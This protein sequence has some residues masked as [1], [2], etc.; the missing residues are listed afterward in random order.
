MCAPSQITK[1]DGG[2]ALIGS[3]QARESKE[4]EPLTTWRSDCGLEGRSGAGVV[5]KVGSL[6]KLVEV[7]Y[8][9]GEAPNSFW[10]GDQDVN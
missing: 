8:R 9:V 4:A 10:M 5:R 7:T 2:F 1:V 3:C 6:E